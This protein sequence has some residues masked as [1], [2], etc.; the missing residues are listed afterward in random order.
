MKDIISFKN[1]LQNIITGNDAE[2]PGYSVKAVP[3]FLKKNHSA[4]AKAESK[5][6]T[7]A[8]EERALILYATENNLWLSEKNFGTYITE[9][10]EQKV[11]F[12]E[13]SDY[14][15]KVADALFYL[16][17]LDYFNNLPLHNTFF[18]STA[19]ELVGFHQKNEKLFVVLKQHFVEVAEMTNLENVRQFMLTNGYVHKKNNDY[20]HPVLGIIVEDLHDENVLTNNGVLFFV[21]TVFYIT[22]NFYK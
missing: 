14:I 12:P 2:G 3:T 9:G 10:A 6:F 1:E 22:D 21:D 7:R 17:W 19:Y 11:F 4:S 5:Q 16:S 18:G 15:V 13:N 20:Y 8:E